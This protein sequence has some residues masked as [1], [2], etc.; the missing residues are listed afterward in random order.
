M[1]NEARPMKKKKQIEF[2]K[3][4]PFKQF[5]YQQHCETGAFLIKN[6]KTIQKMMKHLKMPL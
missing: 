1:L 5:V 4:N 3:L 6:C 2:N